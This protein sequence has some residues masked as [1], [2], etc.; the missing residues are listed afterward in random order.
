MK[1][2][3]QAGVKTGGWLAAAAAAAAFTALALADLPGLPYSGYFTGASGVVNTVQPDSPAE[4]AGLEV[5]DK[6]LL[7]GGIDGS[8]ALALARRPRPAIGESRELASSPRPLPSSRRSARS[9][10]RSA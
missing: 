5:G 4:Q 9:S 1:T 2:Y 6:V 10:P 7:S 3:E 8:G